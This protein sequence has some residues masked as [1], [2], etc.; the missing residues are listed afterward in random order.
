VVVG[1]GAQAVRTALG[2]RTGLTVVTQEPQLGTGHAVLQAEPALAGKRGTLLLLSGDVPLLTAT[3]LQALRNHHDRCQA[4]ATVL[5]M[6]LADPHGYGRIARGHDGRIERIVEQRDAS[7]AE[8]GIREVNTGIYAFALEPLFDALRRTSSQNAQGEYYLTDLVEVYRREGRAV[9]TIAV[10]ESQ[11]VQGVNSR[12]DLAELSA[13][14][15]ARKNRDLM[16]AGV[17]LEDPAATY[18]DDGVTIGEDTILS[19]G[20]VLT[21]RTTIGARCRI[22]GGVRVTDAAIGDDVTILEH[23]VIAESSLGNRVSIGPSAHV[24]P[25]CQIGDEAHIGNYVELKKTVFGRR[26]KAGHLAY[27]GDATI[28]E[29]V[30]IGAGTITCNYDGRTKHPTVIEDGV[31]I[32]SDSQLVAPVTIGRGAYV[33][34]GSSITADVPPGALAIGRG[35]QVNKQDWVATRDGTRTREPF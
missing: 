22:R 15:R 2:S 3:T 19:P 24:R 34:A 21:G 26:S 23:C 25:G 29:D 7:E 14:V 11:E 32:G 13:R 6:T 31:F 5:T 28:G 1:H 30:N 10:G 17:T 33:A 4:A 35:R 27:L 16:L 9:E 18:V 20:V 12:V 8:R